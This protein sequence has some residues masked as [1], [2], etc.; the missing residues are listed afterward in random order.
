ML[1]KLENNC[2]LTK[3]NLELLIINLSFYLKFLTISGIKYL[4]TLNS[5]QK[6][7]VII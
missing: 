2:K 3:R 1:Q 7:L 5:Y 4:I 6:I